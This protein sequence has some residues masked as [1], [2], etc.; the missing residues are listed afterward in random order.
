MSATSTFQSKLNGLV[1]PDVLRVMLLEMVDIASPTGKED[2]L[3]RYVADRFA[4]V[5]MEVKSQEVEP[6]RRNVIATFRGT[7]DGPTL[8]FIGHL[9]SA[10]VA[11]ESGLPKRAGLFDGEWIHGSGASNMKGGFAAYFGAM[12]AI[13][14]AGLQLRGDIVMTAV[15]G[16]TRSPVTQGLPCDLAIIAKPT[17]L[18][19]QP[20]HELS[21]EHPLVKALESAH[22][23]IFFGRDA[24]HLEGYRDSRSNGGSTLDEFGIPMLAYG[25]GGI[26]RQGQYSMQDPE[27]GEL[28]S[29]LNLVMCAKVYAL[30]A[31]DI[32]S[33]ERSAWLAE[34]QRFHR[35]NG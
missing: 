20:G 15:V 31:A 22:R 33:R 24:T 21:R 19:I 23:A 13:Q 14:Q 32:C 18:R 11:H 35:A 5:G 29:V 27:L 10:V 25:P 7:G 2:E 17:G 8:T 9:D 4:R 30:A 34:T 12:K 16:G 1:H 26:D 28:V 3:A 6:G